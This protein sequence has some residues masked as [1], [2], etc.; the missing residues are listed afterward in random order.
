MQKVIEILEGINSTYV[1]SF[2]TLCEQVSGFSASL[3]SLRPPRRPAG[4]LARPRSAPSARPQRAA[5]VSYDDEDELPTPLD[6]SAAAR[7]AHERRVLAQAARASDDE[8][9][10]PA[11]AGTPD[12]ERLR[13]RYLAAFGTSPS[14]GQQDAPP[15]V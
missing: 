7:A 10:A 8:D 4:S 14:P 15:R 6:V 1:P 3:R 9:G 5:A 2:L 13:Q 12:Y 11:P